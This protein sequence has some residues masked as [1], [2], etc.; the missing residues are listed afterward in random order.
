MLCNPFQ[1]QDEAS[2]NTE[3]I[4]RLNQKIRDL[5]VCKLWQFSRYPVCMIFFPAA[6]H[7]HRKTIRITPYP[8]SSI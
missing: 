4:A 7:M 6:C 5:E 1:V 3:E 8:F 2:Y